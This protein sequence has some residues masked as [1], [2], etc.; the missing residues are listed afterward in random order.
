MSEHKVSLALAF[1]ESRPESAARLLELD[2]IDAVA[3]FFVSIPQAYAVPVF[4]H[5]IPQYAARLCQRLEK[6]LMIGILSQMEIKQVAAILRFVEKKQRIAWTKSLPTRIQIG[7]ALLLNYDQDMVG[8][9]VT[10]HV[11]IIPFDC[12]TEEAL[13]YVRLGSEYAPNDFVFA[14][15][16]DGILKGKI[17]LTALLRATSPVPVNAIADTKYQTITARLPILTAAENEDWKSFD[18]IPV[19]DRNHKFIGII[20]HVD[21]RRAIDMLTAKQAVDPTNPIS[22]DQVYGTTLLEV[23]QSMKELVKSDLPK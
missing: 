9:W 3:D 4:K 14:V 6:D 23:F 12:T 2:G 11:P 13:Q 15:G 17:R 21:L 16:S 18:S 7:C 8:A 22:V 1:L 5:M 20:R 19:Q 10:P